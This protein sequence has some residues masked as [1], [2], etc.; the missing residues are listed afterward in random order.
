MGLGQELNVTILLDFLEI[1]IIK[2][3]FVG[4][5]LKIKH[6]GQYSY[7]ELNVEKTRLKHELK[8]RPFPCLD[9]SEYSSTSFTI[10]LE[11][12]HQHGRLIF[13]G[14]SLIINLIDQIIH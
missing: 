8:L 5:S 6:E 4:P 14:I 2:I 10:G 3:N 13:Y 11:S 12:E 7:F 1:F 9:L